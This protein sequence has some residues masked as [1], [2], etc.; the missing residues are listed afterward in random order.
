VWFDNRFLGPWIGHQ[1]PPNDL[2]KNPIFFVGFG[3]TGD[4]PVK[5]KNTDEF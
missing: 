3:Q 5:I 1:V 4:L 2:R